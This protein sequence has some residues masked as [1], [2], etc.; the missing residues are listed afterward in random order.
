MVAK[1]GGLEVD[2]R[3]ASGTGPGFQ[4]DPA[5]LEKALTPRTAAVLVNSPDNPTGAVYG[6]GAP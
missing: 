1:G 4:P 5:I 3:T 2:G 6:Q